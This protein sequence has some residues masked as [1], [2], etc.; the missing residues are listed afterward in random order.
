LESKINKEA[1]TFKFENISIINTENDLVFKVYDD[2]ND[3]LSKFVYTI[4]YD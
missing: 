3:V 4:Y 1:K 2:A